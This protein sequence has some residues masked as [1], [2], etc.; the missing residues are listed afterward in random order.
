MTLNLCGTLQ[1]YTEAVVT[2]TS[3]AWGLQVRQALTRHRFSAVRPRAPG[4]L[5][6]DANVSRTWQLTW[7]NPYPSDSSLYSELSYLVNISNEDDPTEVSGHCGGSAPPLG[8]WW[9]RPRP[10]GGRRRERHRLTAPPGT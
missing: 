5:M 7:S 2:K 9:N 8:T 1:M 10:R 4:N 6:V 3:V